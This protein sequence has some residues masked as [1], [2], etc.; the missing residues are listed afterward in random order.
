LELFQ[1]LL[2]RHPFALGHF[3]V[4]RLLDGIEDATA[5]LLDQKLEPGVVGKPKEPLRSCDLK[6][7]GPVLFVGDEGVEFVRVERSASPIDEARYVVL[8]RLGDVLLLV[9]LG[10]PSLANLSFL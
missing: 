9:L 1:L 10:N 8:D 6:P 3:E 4:P 2:I 7:E 5:G